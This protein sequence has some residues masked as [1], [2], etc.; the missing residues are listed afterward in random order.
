MFTQR[1]AQLEL[2]QRRGWSRKGSRY[3]PPARL[4]GVP[5][6][7]ITFSEACSFEAICFIPN[8]ARIA[9]AREKK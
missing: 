5:K 4:R 6:I 3:Y 1:E 9:I 7:G 2:K 8:K